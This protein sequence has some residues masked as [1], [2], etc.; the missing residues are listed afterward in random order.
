MGVYI[1]PGDFVCLS[2]TFQ[3]DFALQ[4]YIFYADFPNSQPLK[5]EKQ[6]FFNTYFP[7]S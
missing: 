4:S 2:N 7:F 1:F 5:Y 3:G 6:H